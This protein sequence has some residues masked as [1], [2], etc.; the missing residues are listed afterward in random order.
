MA[1]VILVAE[2]AASFQEQAL[3]NDKG[4]L[5]EQPLISLGFDDEV[6]A[7]LRHLVARILEEAVVFVAPDIGVHQLDLLPILTED[8]VW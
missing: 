3:W 1:P 6:D 2:G 7:Q 4:R 8:E 5:A